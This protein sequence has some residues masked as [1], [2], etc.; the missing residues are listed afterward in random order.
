M[1]WGMKP[2]E[3]ATFLHPPV[4]YEKMQDVNEE[5]ICGSKF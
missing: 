2:F 4:Y 5:G 1:C 3:A